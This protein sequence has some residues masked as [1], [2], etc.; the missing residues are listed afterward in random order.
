MNAPIPRAEILIVDDAP[1]IIDILRRV[2]SPEYAIRVAGNARLALRAAFSASP[3][4]LILLDVTMPEMDGYEVCRTLKADDATRAIP[5]IFITARA[6]TDDEAY[7]F[8]IGAADYLVK[9][10]SPPVVLARVRTHL[11]LYAHQRD[12]EQRVAERTADLLARTRELEETRL[13]V[14][15]RLGRAGE[16]R[17]NETGLHLIRL[18]HYA[19]LLGLAVG[20]SD[21]EADQLMHASVLHDIGK[22]G[23]PDRILLKPDRLTSEEFDVI[24]THCQIGAEIIGEHAEG[25]LAVARTIALTHHEKWNGSGYPAGL[26]GEDI[27]L[28]GRI[29]AIADTFDALTSRR[30]YKAPWPLNDALSWIGE[31]AGLC[32]QP[33]L[34][35]RFLAMR[36]EIEA[37][38]H[39]FEDR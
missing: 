16:F 28:V 3:P 35:E 37:I 20:F 10:I 32:F 23:I 25:L 27:P 17:D 14:I 6:S 18:G 12:L 26:I 8:S 13:E 33:Q 11:A 21:A 22:I 9:P 39:S 2:L 38:R 34:V 7:G 4:S 15:R 30:P 24:K 31:R 5:V 29:T 19:R 36:P 1:E